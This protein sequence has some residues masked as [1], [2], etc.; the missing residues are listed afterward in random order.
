MWQ[1]DRVPPFRYF[2]AGEYGTLGDRPHYHVIAFN[3]DLEALLGPEWSATIERDPEYWLTGDK[4]IPCPLW[5]HGYITIGK[6]Q[7]ASIGYTLKYVMKETRIPVHARDDRQPEFQLQ[8]KGLGKNYLTPQM[9][10]WHL[11]DY[12]NRYYLPI[13]DGKKICLPRYYKD[14]IYSKLTRE[15]IGKYLSEKQELEKESLTVQDELR[16]IE[17]SNLMLKKRRIQE[18]F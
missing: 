14:K 3:F 4:P 16:I 10:K 6:V 12:L 5:G 2:L 13:E 1:Y 8:S 7:D 11:T 9:K 17:Y 15:R 18:K